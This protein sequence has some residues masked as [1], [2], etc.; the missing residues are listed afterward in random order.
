MK[1][2]TNNFIVKRDISLINLLHGRKD[3]QMK[4]ADKW[5]RNCH[6]QYTNVDVFYKTKKS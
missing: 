2:L 5:F 6:F 1:F 4:V 3:A